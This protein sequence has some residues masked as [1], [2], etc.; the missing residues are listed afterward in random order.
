M[1]RL[2]TSSAPLTAEGEQAGL[3][4]NPFKL[5]SNPKRLIEESGYQLIDGHIVKGAV[6]RA[7]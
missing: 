1:T 7:H 4:E 5:A 3:Y 6:D 2:P